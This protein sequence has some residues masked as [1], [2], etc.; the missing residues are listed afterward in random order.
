MLA[1]GI[2]VLMVFCAIFAP[3]I[4]PDDPNAQFRDFLLQPPTW[5]WSQ[6]PLGTDE[7]G[8]DLLSRL[9]FGTRLT[10][11]IA[12]LA[13]V[14]AAT[15]GVILGLLA[16]FFPRGLGT[17]ILRL[18]DVLLSFPAVLLAIAIVAVLGP[19]DLNT[20][21]AVAIGSMPGYVRL[22]RA[23]A[24]GEI[25]K[26]YVLAA[27]AIGLGK[28]RLMFV[29]VLPNCLG[30]VIVN[31]TVDFSQ[32][33]LFTAGLGFLGLGAQPP[34]P[35]WGTMLASARDFIDRANWLI[36]WP[37][38]AILVAVVCVNIVGDSLGDATDPRRD[39]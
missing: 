23:S 7:V 10:L 2:L 16:A 28:L 25:A 30:P 9:V 31:A 14:S 8:R 27:R 26:P 38:F 3:W 32:A 21:A 4:A 29:S 6:H 17:A 37:G 1:L 19:S 35:E 39:R 5:H 11:G 34:E 33:I 13:V 24:L 36:A 15:S 18:A 12:S 22:M 20:V